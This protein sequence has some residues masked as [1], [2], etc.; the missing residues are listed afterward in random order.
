MAAVEVKTFTT[1]AKNAFRGLLNH[2][3][4]LC[5]GDAPVSAGEEATFNELR[6][7]IKNGFSV[8]RAINFGA[9]RA[10]ELFAI[11]QHID[12][13]CRVVFPDRD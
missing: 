8:L 1:E 4:D 6:A 10:E 5:E 7:L 13:M 3:H 2:A 9:S 12:K 11:C